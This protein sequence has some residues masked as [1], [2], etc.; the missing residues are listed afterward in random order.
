MNNKGFMMAE[1]IVVSAIILV[2][3]T[4]L[5]LSYGKLFGLYNTRIKYYDSDTLYG[6]AYYRDILIKEDKI[7]STLNTV[8]NNS[9]KYINLFTSSTL[10]KVNSGDNLFI[11]YHANDNLNKVTTATGINKTF[12]DYIEYLKT[13]TTFEANYVMVLERCYKDDCNYA[14]LEVYDGYET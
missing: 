4:G 13:S 5:Y 10:D 8:K 11:I 9:N 2:F 12:K 7:N 14:Y 3:L 1:V 6:L